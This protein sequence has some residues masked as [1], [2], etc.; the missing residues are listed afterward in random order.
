MR[1]F[2]ELVINDDP[3]REGEKGHY[4]GPDQAPDV[5]PRRDFPGRVVDQAEGGGCEDT[6]QCAGEGG[7][8]PPGPVGPH[9]TGD[10]TQMSA[11]AG[12][13]EAFQAI[14]ADPRS[15]EPAGFLQGSEIGTFPGEHADDIRDDAPGAP[16][17]PPGA[18]RE[19][20]HQRDAV[21]RAHLDA[22][23][24]Q[25]CSS[26][27]IGEE[28][29]GLPVALGEQGAYDVGRGGDVQLLVRDQ[30][31]GARRHPSVDVRA[32]PPPQ[33]LRQLVGQFL[34]V[35][36]ATPG[37]ATRTIRT[38]CAAAA[39]RKSVTVSIRSGAGMRDGFSPEIPL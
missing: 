29:S 12:H 5:H 19:Q 34:G 36:D 27:Q 8:E 39:G 20:G 38:A 11:Q 17:H 32:D 21:R 9:H 7:E 15:F 6:G 14:L 30:W 18:E 2:P 23:R 37:S 3:C 10:E 22:D 35:S 1:A 24:A 4:R 33:L 13:D 28:D 26:R 25:A 16:S 31:Y